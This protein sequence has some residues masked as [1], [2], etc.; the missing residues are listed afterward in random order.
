[1]PRLWVVVPTVLTIAAVSVPAA[2]GAASG[3]CKVAQGASI[4]GSTI[5]NL[6]IA[7]AAKFKG[8]SRCTVANS[9]GE[10]LQLDE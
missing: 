5:S 10:G 9:V 4:P 6:M 7:S 8:V 3:G 1:M 2:N